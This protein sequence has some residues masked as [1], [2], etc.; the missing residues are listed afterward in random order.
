MSL[1]GTQEKPPV[2]LVDGAIAIP[3]NGASSTHILKPEA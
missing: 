3:V 2:A 1:A